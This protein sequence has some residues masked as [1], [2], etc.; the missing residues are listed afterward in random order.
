MKTPIICISMLLSFFVGPACL[1]QLEADAGN[2][3]AVCDNIPEV[4]SIGGNPS[5]LGGLPPYEY[6]WSASYEFGNRVYYASHMLEDT[7]V[8]NPIFKDGSIP[9]SVVFCLTVTDANESTASDSVRVRRSRFISCLGECRHYIE[10][11]DSVQLGHCVTGGIPPIQFSWTPNESLSDSTI[12]NPWA[13]PSSNTSYR[14]FITDS[15]GCQT[16]SG[17]RV[18]INPS[19]TSKTENSIPIRIFPIPSNNTIT[20]AIENSPYSSTIF[21]IIASSGKTVYRKIVIEATFS[22]NVQDYSPGVYIYHWKSSN[23]IID[24]GKIIIE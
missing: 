2:D 4:L 19:N 22:V 16:E 11:G 20:I 10:L 23:G 24:S 1:A 9:D 5:A 7:T 8:A 15:I 3:T 12:E 14:L 13:K 17:C 18:F 6:V 21:E